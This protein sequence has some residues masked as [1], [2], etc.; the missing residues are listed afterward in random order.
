[1]CTTLFQHFKTCS[2]EGSPGL[3]LH[4]GSTQAP[5][6]LCISAMTYVQRR[7]DWLVGCIIAL[8]NI[9]GHF[10]RSQL[11]Y[12]HCSWASLLGSLPVLGIHSFANN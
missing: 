7:F 4:L 2:Q 5:I 9:L 1:M 8:Q 3:Y 10:E 11:A 6:L 12:P